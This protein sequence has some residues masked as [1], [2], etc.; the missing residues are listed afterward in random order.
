MRQRPDAVDALLEAWAA[1][2]I[3]YEVYEGTGDSALARFRD[4]VS[5]H[6]GGPRILWHGHIRS[7]L[8]V[9][10]SQ[11]MAELGGERVS[12]LVMLY[13]L[14]GTVAR[15]AQQVALCT[16]TLARLR[17]QARQLAGLFI[18]QQIQAT[19]HDSNP[20]SRCSVQ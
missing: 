8:S 20:L 11:L 9:L 3:T 19:H 2:R 13:G 7:Q 15:K 10:N 12:L 5:T 1:W 16:R 14:P 4:P 18:D 17:K 6:P